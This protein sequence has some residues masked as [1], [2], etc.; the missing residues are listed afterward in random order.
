MS[1]WQAEAKRTLRLL[2]VLWVASLSA[3]LLYLFVI[4]YI[5]RA[6]DWQPSESVGDVL[7]AWSMV[8]MLVAPPLAFYM[9]GQLYKRH[10]VGDAITPQG[11]LLGMMA[12]G[13]VVET[14]SLIALTAVLFRAQWWPT[15]VPAVFCMTLEA[16]HFP[17]GGPMRGDGFAGVRRMGRGD[18]E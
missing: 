6:T 7:Y 16:F 1:A 11:Y 13:A 12:F 2:R 4:L 9:R 8:G 18:A 15:I 14:V 5:L 3:Q 17:T 10:W